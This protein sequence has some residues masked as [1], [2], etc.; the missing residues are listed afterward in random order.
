MVTQSHVIIRPDYRDEPF[1]ITR[2]GAAFFT[3]IIDAA[4]SAGLPTTDLHADN[5]NRENFEIAL[6]TQNPILV[7]IFGHGN[8]NIIVCQYDELLLQGGLNTNILAERVVYNLSCLSGSD[9]ADHAVSE[10][11]VSFLGYSESFT[12]YID[13]RVASGQELT[14]EVARGFFESHNAAPI[15]YINGV[16]LTDSYWTSQDTFDYWIEVWEN[17]DASIVAELM[18]DR[19]HQVMKPFIGERSITSKISPLVIAFAP[20][21]MIPLLKKFK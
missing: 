7:N 15:S 2:Y 10:G 20:L 4:N 16:S 19:D 12:L 6:T 21:L 8:H 5:A 14:D 1:D 11:C 17:I 9:L 13:D 18:W 3:K